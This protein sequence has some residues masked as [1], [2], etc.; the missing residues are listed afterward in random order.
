MYPFL[1]GDPTFL[2]LIPAFIL[3]VYAQMRVQGTFARFLRVQARSGYTGAQVARLLLDANQLQDIPVEIAPGRLTDHYD[4]RRKVM[5]LSADVY[6]GRS[7]AAL[8]VAA[9]ETGHAVQHSQA[10]LPLAVRNS[11]FPIA[12]I[13]TTLAFPLF[14]LGLFMA[15]GWL[16][17]LGIILFTA[18]VAFQVVTLPV[19]FNASG[20]ALAMLDSQGILTRGDEIDGAKKVL[21]A[22][23]LTY[24]AAAA[25]SLLQ[26]FRLLLLRGSRDD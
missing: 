17:D 26:L 13:G 21:N 4:P 2:L 12:N 5:R 9:H 10:Y 20:R 14:V 25:V 6:H 15:S 16:M 19:E 18:A 23:A 1:W 8:G 7:L 22:A 11:V 3:A 24:V